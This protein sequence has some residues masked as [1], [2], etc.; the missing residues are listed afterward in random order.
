MGSLWSIAGSGATRTYSYTSGAANPGSQSV[1]ATNNA[2]GTSA[3]GS[4]TTQADSAAPTGGA[5]SANGTAATGV[6]STSYLNSGTTLTLSGRSDYTDGGSGLAGSVLTIQS[7]ALTGNS[8]GSYGSATT[9]SGTTS[10]TVASGNCYLLTLTGTDFVGN[11]ASVSTTVMVDTTAPSAPTAFSFT[12]LSNAYYPGSGSIVYFLGGSAG[13]FTATATG[14]ADADTGIAS[15]GYGAIGGAGWSNIGNIYSFT[16]ISPTGTGSATASNPAGLTGPSGSFTAQSDTTAPTGGA[17]SAN[18]TAATGVGSSSYLNSGTTLTITGRSDYGETQSATESGL[19]SSNLTMQTGTLS[20]NSC[21]S[22]GAPA[23]ISGMT[24]QT[25][26]SGNCYLLTL[27]GLDNVGNTASVSTTVKVD[28]TAPNAPTGFGFT[29]LSNAYYPGSGTTVYFKGGT[30]GGFTVTASGST[31]ADTGLTGYTYGTIAG[32]G[33]SDAS[34]VYGFTAA[35]PTGTGTVTASNPAGLTSAGTTFTAQNDSTAPTGGAF[36]A[37]GTVATGVG[38]SSYLTSGTT[39]T[40]S[41]RTDYSDAGS[42]IASSTLT[43]QSATLSGNTCGSYGS[44]TP[45]SGTTSQT[46][47]GGNCYLLTLTGTDF[48][49]NT[50]TISTVVKVDTTAPSAPSLAYSAPTNAYYPGSGSIVYFKGGTVGGFTVT[51]SG[52]TDAETGVTGYTYPALGAGWSNASGVYSFAAGAGTQRR[53]DHRPEQRRHLERRHRLHRA[54]RH[55]RADGRGLQRQRARGERR[56]HDELPQRHDAHHRQPHRIRRG[57]DRHCVRAGQL[58][59]D[60]P[61]G[62][63]HRQQLRELRLADHDHRH[64]QPDRRRRQLL[65]AHPPRHRQRR[66]HQQLGEHHG[67]GRHDRPDRADDVQLHRLGRIG[68][69]ARIRLDRLLPGR[70]RRQL[71]RD[72]DRLDRCAVRRRLLQLSDARRHRLVGR[73]DVHVH[74]RV[75]HAVRLGHGDEQRRRRRQR[76]QL[77]R[78]VRHHR[79]PAVRSRPTATPPPARARRAT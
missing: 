6:G 61:D 14:A 15:Y 60:H 49:G 25:V 52:S 57:A 42:G 69:L 68:L 2:G 20:G 18:G 53:I 1:T 76:R 31:D 28:T 32:S 30:T 62:H 23:P 66:Q 74:G 65:P 5:F 40:L 29:G 48:V 33:W 70:H 21:S 34:G 67:D 8:C 27:T 37:N 26:A 3:G 10:Q 78:P 75:D 55:D 17:F 59:A 58:D 35:S 45:I 51:A 11:S 64:R 73:R 71:H 50:A 13:G 79:P 22:Y 9:I 7:A 39:L 16:G 56:R 41:G 24:S 77:H 4:W 19:A 63:V 43:I 46:V 38:S 72:C 54:V 12:G 47:A 44:T 36:T